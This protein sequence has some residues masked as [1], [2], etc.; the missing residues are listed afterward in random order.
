LFLTDSAVKPERLKQV[1]EFNLSSGYNKPF[2]TFIRLEKEFSSLSFCKQLEKGGFVAGNAGLE[3]GCALT[4]SR[5]NKGTD[6]NLIPKILKNLYKSNILI[7]LYTMIGL[8]GETEKEARKTYK[9]LKKYHRYI[10]MDWQVYCLFLLENAPLINHAQF[11]GVKIK[12]LPNNFLLSSCDYDVNNG[13]S[14]EESIG[15]ALL[16]EQKLM[17]LRHKYSKIFDPEECKAFLIFDNINKRN[18]L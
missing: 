11:Y 6:H 5:M 16:F 12:P 15:L 18:S 13:I 1:A 9:F 14:Q 3:S 2:S 10:T 4:N 8:F 7:H 17:P